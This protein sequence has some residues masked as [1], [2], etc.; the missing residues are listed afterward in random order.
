[1]EKFK[2]KCDDLKGIIYVAGS[3]DNFAKTNKEVVEYVARTVPNAGEYRTAI[4]ELEL[5]ALTPPVHPHADA[6]G[7]IDPFDMANWTQQNGIFLKKQAKRESVEKQIFAIVQGQVHPALME[8]VE[9]V[10]NWDTINQNFDVI[11]FLCA[12]RDVETQGGTRVDAIVNM[13]EAESQLHACCQGKRSDAEYYETFKD[14]LEHANRLGASVGEYDHLRCLE[15][16]SMDRVDPDAPGID[17]LEQAT[18]LSRDKYLARLFLK[19]ADDK[20]YG[21][22]KSS[23][24]N[25]RNRN[26]GQYPTSL[27]DAYETITNYVPES[28]IRA[29]RHDGGGFA[30]YG[31]RD[32]DAIGTDNE[33]RPP[34]QPGD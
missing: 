29:S 23:I 1:M 9:A 34:D 12:L 31:D 21:S 20:R 25:L 18:T 11:A 24:K 22:L 4:I 28:T 2:G 19:N 13:Q 17:D 7:V 26:I 6:N 33:H 5:P 3:I 32:D 8:K 30:F 14:R 10:P 27:H 16:E 15:L